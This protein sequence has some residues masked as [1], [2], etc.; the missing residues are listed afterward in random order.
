MWAAEC[1][2]KIDTPEWLETNACIRGCRAKTRI[3]FYFI[4]NTSP[5][6]PTLKKRSL[7]FAVTQDSTSSWSGGSVLPKYAVGLAQPGIRSATVK[8]VDRQ[9]RSFRSVSLAGL[10]QNDEQLDQ[11]WQW[12]ASKP[13]KKDVEGR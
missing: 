11:C 7:S 5:L 12:W 6:P 1:R 8:R 9:R 13:C 4:I 10:H 2:S 3:D